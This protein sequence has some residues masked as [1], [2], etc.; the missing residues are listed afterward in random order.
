MMVSWTTTTGV[1]RAPLFS[2]PFLHPLLLH[3]LLEKLL[4]EKLLLIKRRVNSRGCRNLTGDPVPE[5]HHRAARYDRSDRH[6]LR[7]HLRA[8]AVR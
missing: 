2:L 4:L 6:R 8:V 5:R 1:L 3:L 7:K